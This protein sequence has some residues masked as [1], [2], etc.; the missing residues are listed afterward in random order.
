MTGLE[1][2]VSQILD[3]ADASAAKILEDAQKEADGILAD[4]RAR[5][6]QVTRQKEEQL[7]QKLAGFRERTAS[8]ADMKKR[9]ALLGARQE[10]IS[11]VLSEAYTR[12][13][14]LDDDKYFIML[15]GMAD[16]YALPRAGQIIFSKKDLAR[17]PEGFREEIS[18][19]AEKKGGTLEL[20]HETGNI[21]GGFILTYGGIEENCSIEAM[22]SA[23]KDELQ[24]LVRKLLFT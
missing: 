3:E 5:A 13:L 8:A 4:A 15:K 6:G 14:N 2:R 9:T 19:I 24:D 22:F 1:K 10:L 7:A 21:D 23:K 11:Q 17:L 18:K 20:S 16:K 12:V